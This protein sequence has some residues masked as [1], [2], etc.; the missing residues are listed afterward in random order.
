MR[1]N[2]KPFPRPQDTLTEP[3]RCRAKTFPFYAIGDDVAGEN[4]AHNPWYSTAKWQRR[5]AHQL[6]EH[7]L[8]ALCEAKGLPVPATIADHINP[9]QGDTNSFWFGAL[10]SL[11]ATCHSGAKK[12]EEYKANPPRHARQFSNEVGEDGW[13]IDPAHPANQSREQ[14]HE[15]RGIGGR[16]PSHPVLI[17][18]AG[19]GGF[20]KTGRSFA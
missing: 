17:S 10:Q 16:A 15:P 4:R 1:S 9:H 7:P 20:R 5:R 18:R 19:R 12:R 3:V 2:T 8:C 6:R 11:C 13:P 14:P